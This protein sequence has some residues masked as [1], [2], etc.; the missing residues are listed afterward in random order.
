[1]AETMRQLEGEFPWWF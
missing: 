1:M